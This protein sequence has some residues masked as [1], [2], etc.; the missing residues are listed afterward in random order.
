MT[1]S[2]EIFIFSIPHSA[3]PPCGPND[4]GGRIPQSRSRKVALQVHGLVFVNMG[5][6]IP[7]HGDAGIFIKV[8]FII[9]AAMIDEKIL[10]LINEL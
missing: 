8:V 6:F 4:L 9:F 7:Y 10:F 3:T 1:T 5:S 2:Y